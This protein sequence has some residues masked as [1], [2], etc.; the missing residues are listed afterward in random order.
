[1]AFTLLAATFPLRA[2]AAPPAAAP[3]SSGYDVGLIRGEAQV[4]PNDNRVLL[5]SEALPGTAGGPVLTFR[6]KGAGLWATGTWLW[7]G[8]D[9]RPADILLFDRLTLR[10]RVVG[11]KPPGDVSVALTSLP[12]PKATTAAGAATV[13]ASPPARAVAASV[14]LSDFVDGLA[15]GEW[16][17]L[18][19]PL[20]ALRQ[21]PNGLDPARVD[22]LTFSTWNEDADFTLYVAQARFEK[23]PPPAP[24]PPLPPAESRHRVRLEKVKALAKRITPPMTRSEVEALFPVRDGGF[25]P[26]GVTRYVCGDEVM[27]EVPYDATGGPGDRENRVSGPVKVYRAARRTR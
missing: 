17:T 2:E 7:E 4:R 27:V 5:R 8:A 19:V 21:T 15:D 16:H 20:T 13:P 24:P 18:H 14:R 26:Y 12:L 10:L 23:T 1:M 11:P 25:A 6:V 9:K 3:S 22:G